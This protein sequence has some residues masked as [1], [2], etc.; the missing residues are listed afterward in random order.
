MLGPSLLAGLLAAQAPGALSHGTAIAAIRTPS[1]VAIAAD[2]R[3]VDQHGRRRPDTCKIRIAGDTVFAVHGMS[4]HGSGLDLFALASDAARSAPDLRSASDEIAARARGPIRTA[5]ASLR[6]TDPG[7][8][9]R[10]ALG[11]A[12]AGVVLAR[13]EKE[14]AALSYVRFTLRDP[15]G[16]LKVEAEIRDCPGRDCPDGVSAVFVGPSGH[17]AAFQRT[18]TRYWGRGYAR[19][20][21]SFVE[22]EA[23]HG[24]R[25]IGGPVQVI[26]LRGGRIAWAQRSAPCP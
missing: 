5:L 17:V 16:A 13:Y 12:P 19:N 4:S 1:G 26:L 2:S 24:H 20:A 8:F 3:V 7:V 11:K 18:H 22:A 14:G 15:D 9:E 23:S 6:E 21:F 25:D 10:Y